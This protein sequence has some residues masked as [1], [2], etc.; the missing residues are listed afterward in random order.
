MTGASHGTPAY[1]APEQVT[2]SQV[3]PPADFF[4]QQKTAYEMLT[5]AF[6][7]QDDSVLEMLYAHVH[8]DPVAPSVRRPD[9]G[10]GVDA[11]ILRGLARDPIARWESCEAFVAALRSALEAA[12]SAVVERTLVLAPPLAATV[13][14]ARPKA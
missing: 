13:P 9:L 5:G 6:P 3:G 4:S 8:R 14:R 12:P 10:S 11:V 7:Y 2:G 1:R